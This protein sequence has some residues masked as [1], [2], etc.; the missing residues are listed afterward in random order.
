MINTHNE[1]TH[2]QVGIRTHRKRLLGSFVFGH[3]ACG[4][5]VPRPGIKS[6]DVAVKATGLPG[7]SCRGSLLN[8][9]DCSP[10]IYVLGTKI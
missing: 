3:T 2:T 10:M 7:N 5:L 4:I 1:Q 8:V 6:R 9:L